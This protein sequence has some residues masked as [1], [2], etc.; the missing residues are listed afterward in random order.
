MGKVAPVVMSA[1]VFGGS[2]QF[3][4]A[5]ILAAGGSAVAAVVAAL[6]LNGRYGPMALAAAPA[7]EGGRARRA[8]EA[9]LVVDESW[10]LASRG[11]GT[12]DRP[13]LLVTGL[14]LYAGWVGGTLLG[15][16]AGG[17]I[18]DPEDLGLDAAFP[19]LFLALLATQV[20]SRRTLA[21]ALLGAGLALAL[22]PFT[23]AGVPV[24]AATLVCLVGL[25]WKEERE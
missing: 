19:A 8:V 12:F 4:V 22:V 21:A 11:D 18:G 9:Q 3:A 7:L 5:S 17:A 1:T 25:R 23:P 6:L 14:I 10:A 2:A 15:V 13:T 16:L 20:N 24:I